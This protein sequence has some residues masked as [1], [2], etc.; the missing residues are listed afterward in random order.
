MQRVKCNNAQIEPLRN[1][2]TYTGMCSLLKYILMPTHMLV[3]I[4]IHFHLL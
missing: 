2:N 4:L 3:C 1:M